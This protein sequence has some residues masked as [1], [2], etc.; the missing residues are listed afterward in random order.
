MI[1]I[2]YLS[3]YLFNYWHLYIAYMISF[4][5][6]Y[7]NWK[8]QIFIQLPISVKV[9]A[10][11]DLEEQYDDG[12]NR[13]RQKMWNLFQNMYQYVFF[14]I[15]TVMSQN[16]SFVKLLRSYSI[17]IHMC[18]FNIISYDHWLCA[19][20]FLKVRKTN[21]WH[22]IKC[23]IFHSLLD[24]FFCANES[25][26]SSVSCVHTWNSQKKSKRVSLSIKVC[27]LVVYDSYGPNNKLYPCH[28]KVFNSSWKNRKIRTKN[29]I[30]WF[31]TIK[32]SSPNLWFSLIFFL[33]LTFSFVKYF[34][35][36]LNFHRRKCV[37]GMLAISTRNRLCD[38]YM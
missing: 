35:L 13:H 15:W 31:H 26:Y 17:V 11:K 3:I 29:S 36:R 27:F 38:W 24:F 33:S 5:V 21:Y 19:V 23:S 6:N 8:E 28:N 25:S 30:D 14:Q 32:C 34:I 4:S 18:G 16:C 2:Y 10:K 12:G 1:V 7:V 9:A 22:W 37:D 20:F